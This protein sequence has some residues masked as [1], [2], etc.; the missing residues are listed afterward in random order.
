METSEREPLDSPR[1]GSPGDQSLS[2]QIIHRRRSTSVPDDYSV[3]KTNDDATESKLVAIKMGYY[4]DEYLPFIY[5]LPTDHLARRDPEISRGYW[6]RVLAVRTIVEKFLKTAGPPCQILNIGCGFDTLYWRLKQ[7][8]AEF[9]KFLDVDFS[10]VTAKKI[11][12]IHKHNKEMMEFFK[13]KP[14]ETQHSDLY[15][16]DYCLIGA[17]LRQKHEFYAKLESANVDFKAPTIVVCECV[18]V[19]MHLHQSSA[20]INNLSSWFESLVFLNYEQVNMR[21]CFG[22]V[23][24]KNLLQRG[25]VFE[26]LEACENLETQKERFLNIGCNK[27][28]SWTMWE[29]YQNLLP[30]EERLRLAFNIIIIIFSF[31]ENCGK[32]AL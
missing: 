26:G 2:A 19:Y 16:G 4:K 29:I 25:I 1:K 9:S 6:A 10:T 8:K 28:H 3:Q 20:L 18:M 17:D 13:E 30:R 32:V 21:D 22:E 23:M 11:R 15:A 12:Q 24:Q 27:V 7:S 31:Y 5:S 14:T